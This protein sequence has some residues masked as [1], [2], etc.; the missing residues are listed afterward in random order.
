MPFPNRTESYRESCY[1][2]FDQ[3]SVR[4]GNRTRQIMANTKRVFVHAHNETLKPFTQHTLRKLES[5][6]QN[7]KT[8]IN[9]LTSGIFYL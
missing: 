4:L 5:D 2:G 1:K 7:N 6:F 8:K 9:R 3:N